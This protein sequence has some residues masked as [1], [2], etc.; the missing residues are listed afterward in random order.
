MAFLMKP[1]KTSEIYG[2]NVHVGKKC[3]SGCKL[4]VGL[5]G[6]VTPPLICGTCMSL[7]FWCAISFCKQVPKPVSFR[8]RVLS[9]KTGVYRTEVTA[10][11]TWS[12]NSF[13]E[14]TAIHNI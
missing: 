9:E 10:L 3:S 1:K 8:P 7:S 12:T 6:V 11:F 5:K 4:E 14:N 13:I 2:E